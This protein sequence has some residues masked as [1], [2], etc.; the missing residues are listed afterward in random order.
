MQNII[1]LVE[2]LIVN[3]H[4]CMLVR[5]LAWLRSMHGDAHGHHLKLSMISYTML[6][7]S[8]LIILRNHLNLIPTCSYSDCTCVHYNAVPAIIIRTL[9]FFAIHVQAS[10]NSQSRDE[11]ATIMAYNASKNGSTITGSICITSIYELSMKQ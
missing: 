10:V 1:I 5:K 2:F 11:L 8:S 9:Y 7:R 4:T 3:I 6:Y